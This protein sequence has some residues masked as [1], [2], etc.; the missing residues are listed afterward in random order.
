MSD[1]LALKYRPIDFSEVIGQD[2]VVKQLKGALE[3]G[4]LGH[5]LLFCGTRG[6]GKTTSARLLVKALNP[7]IPEE[8]LPLLSSEIDAASNNGVDDI[9]QIIENI[10]YS[11]QGHRV[12]IL[13]E[14]H[15]LSKNAWNAALKTLE[16]PP[17][18]TTF[19]LITTEP[20]KVPAT[21]RSR[22]QIYEFKDVDLDTLK[23]HYST[24]AATEGLEISDKQIEEVALRAE[25]SVRDG[26]SLLQKH[27]SGEEVSSHSS[28]Y[29]DL[30]GAIYS[31]DTTRA[32]EVVA[33][34]RKKEEAR[35]VIQT[36]EKWF[37]W[38]SLEFFG[39]KTPARQF[40]DEGNAQLFDLG[41]LQNLFSVCLSIERDL[42]ATPNSKIV[43]EMGIIRLCQ[44]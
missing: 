2:V 4:K 44:Q 6:T 8:Q 43:L 36:L 23:N 27:L 1:V 16:E 32:L 41:K 34:L 31:G 15:M 5:A 17:A 9:R 3:K 12:V 11:V 29:F 10:R 30:V 33:G 7:G 21:V 39:S 28:E 22:C 37:Y 40:L 24:V 18:N 19:V 42:S 13:D 20:N 25:G 38:C 35:T 14:A 26:L